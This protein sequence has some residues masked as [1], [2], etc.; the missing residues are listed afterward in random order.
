MDGNRFFSIPYDNRNDIT[1][2]RM[3]KTMGGVAAYGRWVSLLG[4]LYDADG[5]LDMSDAAMREIVAE[6]L[7]LEDVDGFFCGLCQ[8]ELIDARLYHDTNH[9]VCAGVCDQL[10]YRKAKS[11]AGRRG[12]RK[13]A[14]SS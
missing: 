3:K 10:Q 11:E 6:E 14:E 5:L 13:K 7:E 1:I 8:L 9:V 12:G 2:R 4:M